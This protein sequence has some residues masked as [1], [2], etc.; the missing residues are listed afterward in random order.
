A[1]NFVAICGVSKVLFY[2]YH[3][4]TEHFVGILLNVEYD[5]VYVNNDGPVHGLVVFIVIL[6][7]LWFA[8]Y[9]LLRKFVRRT[10]TPPTWAL[11][12]R[13]PP[14]PPEGSGSTCGPHPKCTPSRRSLGAH[15]FL[16]V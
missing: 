2:R 10:P 6:M 4:G 8:C 14:A 12:Y 13:V 1:D 7:N 15:C 3:V 5:A 11:T 16:T 9:A